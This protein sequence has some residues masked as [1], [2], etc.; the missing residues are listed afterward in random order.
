MK[1]FKFPKK[2]ITILIGLLLLLQ[3]NYAQVAI[4]TDGSEAD[5]SAMLDIKS[6]IKGLLVPRM[7]ETQRTGIANPATGLLVYQIDTDS[8]FYYNSGNASPIWVKLYSGNSSGNGW[9]TL[10]NSSTVPGTNFIGTIDNQ[11]LDLRTHDTIRVRITTKGQ[12]EVLNTGRSVFIGEEAGANDDFTNNSNVF[13]GDSTGY[14]NTS[15]N[16]NVAVGSGALYN[17]TEKGGI[18]AIGNMALH[19]NGIGATGSS[20]G[21]YNCAIG[22]AAL[23]Q[24]TTGNS[25]TAVGYQSLMKNETGV[26]NVGV[27]GSALFRNIG[28]DL[29]VAIGVGASSNNT[30]GSSNVAMGTW[31]LTMSD[32]GSY[33]TAIGRSGMFNNVSG[34]SNTSLGCFSMSRNI[35]GDNNVA[36]GVN[37]LYYNKAKSYNTAVGYHAMYYSDSSSTEYDNYNTA[38][39][40]YALQGSSSPSSNTGKFNTAVGSNAL[41]A[42]TIG[43][44]NSSNGRSSLYSNTTGSKNTSMGSLS[45]Y[46]NIGGENNS[47]IGY[48]SLY[49]NTS[50]DR[51]TAIGYGALKSNPSGDHNT[52]IGYG[53]GY[54][55]SGSDNV[56]IGYK[57][58]YNATGDSLLYINNSDNS[59]PLIYG[60]FSSSRIGFGTTSPDAKLDV[61]SLVGEDALRVRVGTATKLRVHA[62]GSV[63]VGTS[64]EGPAQGLESLGNIEPNSHKGADLG[65]DGKAWDDIYYDDLH[66][67][68]ASA[69]LGRQL[70]DEIVNHP[71][72]G[73]LPGS[74]DYK[75]ERGD[76]EL[77]P[78]S[79]PSGLAD[80]NSLLTDE[81]SSYNYKTNYEQQII[82][83]E[84][85]EKIR[86]LENRLQELEK[87]ADRIEA[88][89][90]NK[91]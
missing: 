39:G 32:S 88:L 10:G 79:M 34:S 54:S 18:V 63:S 25:N 78:K 69:F 57:A 12:I 48:W 8:G 81:I 90:K 35:S 15:G 66:N 68:G 37:A 46:S 30:S 16:S 42:N 65:A 72:T 14:M 61:R 59:T 45:M 75:T 51:N 31:A 83:N 20:D 23:F 43:G 6:E 9:A 82:I 36:I 49:A 19:H 55:N 3:V 73:K 5:G 77:D 71:P 2:E 52:A 89:E 29:N 4:N 80:D 26:L 50:G 33:N 28:G 62:N 22:N 85:K 44:S 64:S 67:Q 86:I 27:G 47:A 21:R 91:N 56:F 7:T 13:L 11:A 74:F 40:A 60:N 24:N 41:Y 84:Q 87:L 70:T 58:G 76:V 17:N 1:L 53:A 38:L